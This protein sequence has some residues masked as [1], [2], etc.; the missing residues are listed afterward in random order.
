MPECYLPPRERLLALGMTP[1]Y[2]VVDCP[3]WHWV[4]DSI[5]RL[6]FYAESGSLVLTEGA[7]TR[8]DGR[9]RGA[10]EFDLLLWQIGW[11][12]AEPKEGVPHDS[13]PG[14][15]LAEWVHKFRFGDGVQ[16]RYA[17][18]RLFNCLTVYASDWPDMTLAEV[19]EHL[20]TKDGR[21]LYRRIRNFGT[22]SAREL[23]ELLIADGVIP[24]GTE[25]PAGY[26]KSKSADQ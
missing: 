7:H 26:P 9:V 15:L 1:D 5:R 11:V 20:T 24:S 25:L 16:G 14:P 23:L 17:S 10:A 4:V 18:V 13:A 8:F 12:D 6:R 22:K 3:D 21:N 2:D 19:A